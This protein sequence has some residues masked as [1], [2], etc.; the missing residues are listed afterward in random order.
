MTTWRIVP[1]ALALSTDARKDAVL[2]ELIEDDQREV[3]R[4]A[5]GVL[6]GNKVGTGR[7]LSCP[8]V[9]AHVTRR[10]VAVQAI[11]GGNVDRGA[12][13]RP[14]TELKVRGSNPLGRVPQERL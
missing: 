12:I 8:F 4:A 1:T 14:P 3:I 13:A 11:S 5:S 9:A 6:G 10:N 7:V 2:D